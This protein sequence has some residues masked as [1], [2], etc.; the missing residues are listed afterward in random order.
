MLDDFTPIIHALRFGGAL[1][2]CLQIANGG[3]FTQ[4]TTAC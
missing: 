2:F 1:F 4:L 3:M